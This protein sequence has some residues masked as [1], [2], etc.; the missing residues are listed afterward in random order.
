MPIANTAGPTAE[1]PASDPDT[2]RRVVQE[3]RIAREQ[4][5]AHRAKEAHWISVERALEIEGTSDSTRLR[6][7]IKLA[8]PCR[9]RHRGRWWQFKQAEEVAPL[10]AG[11]NPLD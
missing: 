9:F 11:R 1:A 10:L 7:E 4:R 8:L 2:A 5:E 3:R 6:M